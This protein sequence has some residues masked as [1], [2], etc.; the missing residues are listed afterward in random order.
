MKTPID[1]DCGRMSKLQQEDVNKILCNYYR[2]QVYYIHVTSPHCGAFWVEQHDEVGS[3]YRCLLLKITGIGSFDALFLLVLMK[4]VGS[5]TFFRVE[6]FV[7]IFGRPC[8]DNLGILCSSRG[9]GDVGILL[10]DSVLTT[11]GF[12][13]IDTAII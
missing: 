13:S 6:Q 4:K 1:I 11:Q 10:E 8:T 9:R 5:Y 2:I 3:N 12:G 7:T